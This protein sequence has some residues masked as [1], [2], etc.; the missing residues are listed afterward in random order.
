MLILNRV[1]EPYQILRCD[2]SGELIIRGEYYYKDTD[3]EYI[4][5]AS[6]YHEIKEK[7][8]KETFDYSLL[9]KATSEAEYNEMLK[10]AEKEFLAAGILDR[11][12][13]VNGVIRKSG[14]E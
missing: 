10:L 1:L 6:V 7:R 9:E 8:K 5:K 13:L 11:E 3:D 14:V 4:I 12:I 2:Y